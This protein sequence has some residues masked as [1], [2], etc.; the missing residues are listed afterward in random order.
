LK[1]RRSSSKEERRKKGFG[2]EAKSVEACVLEC[3]KV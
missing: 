1:G 2:A 3:R